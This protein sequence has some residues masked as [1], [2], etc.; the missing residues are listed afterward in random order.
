FGEEDIPIWIDDVLMFSG[1]SSNQE[2]NIPISG[3]SNYPNPFNIETK[4]IFN[5]RNHS[6]IDLCIY[7][8][9]GQLVKKII[10][11]QL[12]SG[13]YEIIWDGKDNNFNNCSSGIYICRVNVNGLLFERKMIFIK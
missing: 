12:K 6:K 7:N 8:I 9:R 11:S 3:C 5:L 4:I 2:N 13:N 1:C 10:S